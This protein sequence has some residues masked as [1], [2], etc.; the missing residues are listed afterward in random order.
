MINSN[1]ISNHIANDTDCLPS[2]IM[3]PCQDSPMKSS[4]S[5]ELKPQPQKIINLKQKDDEIELNLEMAKKEL[6]SALEEDEEH[7]HIHN[8]KFARRMSELLD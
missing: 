1:Q 3:E 6:D 2:P 8:E 7:S 5:Y 4:V